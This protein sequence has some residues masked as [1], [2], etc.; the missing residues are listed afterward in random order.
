MSQP[1]YADG[2]LLAPL[3]L[4]EMGWMRRRQTSPR[5]KTE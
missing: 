5:R 3:M 4:T 1:T 2:A